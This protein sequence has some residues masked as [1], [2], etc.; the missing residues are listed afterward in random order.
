MKS[1]DSSM[2]LRI[3]I[4]YESTINK[5]FGVLCFIFDYIQWD[6]I[7]RVSQKSSAFWYFIHAWDKMYSLKSM[8]VKNKFKDCS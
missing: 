3:G 7:Y 4:N 1:Y 5:S 8:Y 2:R 6:K